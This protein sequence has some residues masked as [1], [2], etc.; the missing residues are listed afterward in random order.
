MTEIGAMVV[1]VVVVGGGQTL[2]ER[3]LARRITL[4]RQT[5]V[6]SNTFQQIRT[7]IERTLVEHVPE[8]PD[9]GRT[10]LW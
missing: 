4:F 5:G 3:N 10:G 2:V 1:V 7:L 9:F 8:N 6:W